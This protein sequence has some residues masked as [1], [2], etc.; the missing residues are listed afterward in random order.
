MKIHLRVY[1]SLGLKHTAVGSTA[2][3]IDVGMAVDLVHGEELV[4]FADAY[5]RCG[6][7]S[8]KRPQ[9]RGMLCG[10]QARPDQEA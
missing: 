3:V 5:H 4:I 10:A 7:T 2:N 6:Q 1:A 8:R 9:R